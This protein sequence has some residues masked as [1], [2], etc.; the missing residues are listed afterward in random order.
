MVASC[1]GAKCSPLI[2]YAVLVEGTLITI[3]HSVLYS[4]HR[5]QSHSRLAWNET[6]ERLALDEVCTGRFALECGQS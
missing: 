1:Q 3:D 4:S 6:S 2:G 5:L